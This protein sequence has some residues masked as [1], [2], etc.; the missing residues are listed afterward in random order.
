MKADDFYQL[1]EER[2]SD[3]KFDPE[4]PV[5]QE[6]LM[7]VLNAARLAPSA[8]NSQPWSFMVVTDEKLR[9]AVAQACSS[10][11]LAMNHFTRQAPVHVLILEDRA[12]FAATGGG[13]IKGVH[14][15]H[16]DIGIAAAHLTLAAT[17]EGLGSCI[18]GW[19]NEKKIREILGIPSSK[20]VLLNVLMGYSIDPARS[21]KRKAMD[22]ILHIDKW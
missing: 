10:R 4:K 20:R 2:Q 5:P 19:L 3:R 22:E 6:L 11:V 7:R 16:F 9:H 8:C 15:A 12:N 21:K 18:V 1:V 17:A 13:K 14:Y